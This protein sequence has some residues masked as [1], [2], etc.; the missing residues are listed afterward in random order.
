[1]KILMLS[2]NYLPHV[3]GVG[4][5]ITRTMRNLEMLGHDIELVVPVYPNYV[6]SNPK[7]HRVPSI[8]LAEPLIP[9]PLPGKKYVRQIVEHFKPNIMHTHHPF[10]LGKTALKIAKEKNIPI[11]MTYHA[12]YEEYTHYVPLLPESILKKYV[13]RNVRHF[14]N[15]LD[16]VVAP[17]ESI[18]KILHER[19]F[20]SPIHVIPTGINPEYFITEPSARLITRDNW[21]VKEKDIVIIS[22]ARLAK[23]KNFNLLLEAFA[24]ILQKTSATVKLVLGGDG[25]AKSDLQKTAEKLG[26]EKNTIFTGEIPHE[27]VP[28]FLAGGDIFAY[29]SLSETQGLVT[30]EALASG[31]PAVVID[32][33]G[34]RDVVQNGVCGLVSGADL[35]SFSSALMRLISEENLRAEF[36]DNA[37]R[38]ADEFSEIRMAKK[39]GEF[40]E[41]LMEK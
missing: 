37:K 30:L 33:P 26:I 34:N 25:P 23:E 36:A 27:N 7:I 5:S 17:S 10:L 9:L 8:P 40:Y 15:Q 12:M 20:K 38:R 21:N 3:S 16:A 32:A 1:M 29:P 41:S 39:M 22:F 2:N 18:S 19:N 6:E 14:A 35:Q 24:Q 13:I 28:E 31:L 11:V 4:T